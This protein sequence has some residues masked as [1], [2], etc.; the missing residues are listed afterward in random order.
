MDQKTQNIITNVWLIL[1]IITLSTLI[2]KDIFAAY[3]TFTENLEV[4]KSTH[5]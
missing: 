2:N 4:H 3:P 1:I 5:Q